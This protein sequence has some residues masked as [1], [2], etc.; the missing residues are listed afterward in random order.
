MYA[1]CVQNPS[2]CGIEYIAK[3]TRKKKVKL[4]EKSQWLKL[5]SHLRA[6]NQIRSGCKLCCRYVE[7]IVDL[8]VQIKTLKTL[9]F[10]NYGRESS[11]LAL[12]SLS[13][14]CVCVTWV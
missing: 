5:L 14:G 2:C 13:I 3:Q 9:K 10:F 7:N 12:P 4:E 8:S 11:L 1:V 6:E